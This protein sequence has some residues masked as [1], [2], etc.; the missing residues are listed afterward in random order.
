MTT[1]SPGPQIRGISSLSAPVSDR[2]CCML[3]GLERDLLRQHNV[4]DGKTPLRPEAPDC[5]LHTVLVEFV[6][7]HLTT[8]ADAIALPAVA[9]R[10][11]EVPRSLV[12]GKLDRRQPLFQQFERFLRGLHAPGRRTVDTPP[13]CMGKP[14]YQDPQKYQRCKERTGHQ[15]TPF[16]KI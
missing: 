6:N 12:L 1:I 4:A 10:H 16:S 5:G 11:F 8:A 15:F 2:E 7:I 14:Q 13:A 3:I 9:A